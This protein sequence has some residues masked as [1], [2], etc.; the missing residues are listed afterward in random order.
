MKKICLFLCAFFCFANVGF[1][2]KNE[3]AAVSTATAW[4]Q[5]VDA[6]KYDQSWQQ[7][8]SMFR[9]HVTEQSWTDKIGAVR[10]EFGAVKSR[11]LK[12]AT[13]ATSLPGAPDG[14]YVVVQFDTQFETKQH[15]VETITPA[16]ESNGWRV[17]GYYIK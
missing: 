12:S 10:P 11:T 13:Y 15:A 14:Q 5:L 3:D 8:A 4:L 7:S 1:A 9:S 17:S 2:G 16:L 6:G